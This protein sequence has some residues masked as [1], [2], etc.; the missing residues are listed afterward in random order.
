MRS[1]VIVLGC[2]LWSSMAWAEYKKTPAGRFDITALHGEFEAA[3]VNLQGA[4]C[5]DESKTVI[6]EKMSGD[7]TDAEK[8]AMDAKLAVHD[9]DIRAKRQAQ[10]ERDLVSGNAKLKAMGLTEA[11]IVAMK[12]R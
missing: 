12:E 6:C 7:F 4:S 10:Q 1:M 9:P 3:G 5:R 2:L 8:A 11:E